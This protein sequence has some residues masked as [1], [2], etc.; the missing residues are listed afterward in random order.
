MKLIVTR[1]QH[2]VTTRYISSWAE[3]IISFAKK[4]GVDV[5]DLFKNKAN[6][7]QFEG[8][9]NKIRPEL[10]FI[11]G[12]GNDCCVTGHDNLVLVEVDENQHILK[13]SITYALSCNSG[14]ELGP[15]VVES[16]GKAYIGYTDEFIFVFDKDYV[17]KPL[18][19]P[20][21]KPFMEASNQ[22]MISLLKGNSAEVSSIKS[23]NKFEENRKSLLSSDADQD[24]ILAA[25]FLWWN[26]RNQVCLGDMDAK[27]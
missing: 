16:G 21:A 5:F 10:I 25:Q 13:D 7:L 15:K 8:R 22:V 19:D 4:K 18:D 24:S 9:V 12:H 23:K 20:K 26:M 2:D 1:P 27:C 3:E 11:N 14:K 6:K 17:A